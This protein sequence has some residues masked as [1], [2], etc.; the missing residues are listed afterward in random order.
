[1]LRGAALVVAV[2]G[3]AMLAVTAAVSAADP[4]AAPPPAGPPVSAPPRPI[5]VA[6]SLRDPVLQAGVVKGREVILARGFEAALARV[7][8]RR[9]GVGIDRFVYV[10][11]RTRLL[12]ASGASWDVALDAIERPRGG[13]ADLTASYLT[14][15]VAVVTRRGLARPRSVSELRGA[16][17]CAVRG[18]TGASAAAALRPRV[19][20]L[21]VAGL[22]RLR[23]VLRTGTCDAALVPAVQAGRLLAGQRGLLG[24][25]VGRLRR[26]DGI[27]ASVPAGSSLDRRAVDRELARL[28]RDGTLGRLARLWLG[29]DPAALAVLR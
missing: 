1:M 17:L 3:V 14:S 6:L 18:S 23:S 21:A 9:L 29:L 28:R 13:R 25:V 4:P 27:G 2:A 5:V 12:A 8:A 26:G 22:D 7:L 19:P 20:T 15:D 24:P 16:Y 11:S 10:P